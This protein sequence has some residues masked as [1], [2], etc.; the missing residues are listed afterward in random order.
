MQTYESGRESSILQDIKSGTKTV[1][2]RLARGKF[3]KYQLGD[4]VYLRED[5]Y[6]D[7][8][9]VRSLPKQ[10]LVEITKTEKYAGFREMLDTVG[11]EYVMPRAAN[12]DEALQTC[13]RF[14]TAEEE[15]EFGALSVHFQ[16]VSDVS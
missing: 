15:A 16:L 3:L 10:C 12:I 14:Y 13:Y 7:D 5:F 2:A 4:Q 11:Y 6:E 8:T 9:I 1:E